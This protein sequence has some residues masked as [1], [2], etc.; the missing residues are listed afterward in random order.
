MRL[1]ALSPLRLLRSGAVQAVRRRIS[2]RVREGRRRRR[3][4]QEGVR[5]DRYRVGDVVASVVVRVQGVEAGRE[6]SALEEIAEDVDRI[7]DI[8]AAVA[9]GI[10]AQEKRFRELA[11]V[12]DPVAVLVGLI[13]VGVDRAVVLVVRDPVVVR[14]VVADVSETVS[15]RIGLVRDR[16]ERTVVDI[17]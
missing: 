16:S 7:G 2:T 3:L 12:A 13:Q 10:A 9:I 15:V 4:A 8:Q 5:D 1:C 6:D 17:V 14:V 11:D